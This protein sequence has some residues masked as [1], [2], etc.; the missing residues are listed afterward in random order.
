VRLTTAL[1]VSC[2]LL[3]TAHAADTRQRDSMPAPMHEHM[4]ANMRDHLA[5]LSEI[6]A[7]LAAGRYDQAADVAEQRIGM[8]SLERHGA[9]HMAPY[10]PKAMQDIGT[11]MHRAA[12]RLARAAQ[13]ASVTNEPSHALGALAEL[14]QQCVACHAS[15]R[16]K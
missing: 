16:L 3:E 14:T 10:M 8:S 15:F 13:E 4:L 6:Q 5:A 1:L 9:S 11:N 2:L 7:A 12:S